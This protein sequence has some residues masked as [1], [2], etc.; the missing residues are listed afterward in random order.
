MTK[1]AALLLVRH[2]AGANGTS[3]QV[4][5]ALRAGARATG[6]ATVPARDYDQLEVSVGADTLVAIAAV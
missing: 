5:S 4:S 6:S 3:W 2:A 1:S